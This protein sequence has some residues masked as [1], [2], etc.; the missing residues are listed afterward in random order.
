MSSLKGT[1]FR[2]F[3]AFLLRNA[4]L[5]EATDDFSAGSRQAESQ[6]NIMSDLKASRFSAPV[7]LDSAHSPG[8]SCTGLRDRHFPSPAAR[9]PAARYVFKGPFLCFFFFIFLNQM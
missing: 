4:A 9:F 5:E 8:G 6:N 1:S 3:H 7:C 2:V